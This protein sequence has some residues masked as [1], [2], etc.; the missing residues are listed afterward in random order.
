MQIHTTYGAT[1]YDPTFAGTRFRHPVPQ[2]DQFHMVARRSHA[3]IEINAALMRHIDSGPDRLSASATSMSRYAEIG[4][5]VSRNTQVWMTI[6]GDLLQADLSVGAELTQ[7]LT[8]LAKMAAACGQTVMRGRSAL[9]L[10]VEINL[11]GL[12]NLQEAIGYLARCNTA[13]ALRI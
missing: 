5:I 11:R 9:R 4:A 7:R 2:L 8:G 12:A 6:A 1:G 10:L 3:L 13:D